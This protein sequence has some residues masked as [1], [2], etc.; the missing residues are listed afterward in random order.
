[1]RRDERP[2][3]LAMLFSRSA[4]C[5]RRLKYS[6]FEY[7]HRNKER[8]LYCTASWPA[9][10]RCSP[11]ML[12]ALET[13]P[14]WRNKFWLRYRRKTTSLLTRKDLICFTIFARTGLFTCVSRTMW[15]SRYYLNLSTASEIL[16]PNLVALQD[17]QR[18]RAFL[19]LNE[20]KRRFQAAYGQGAQTALAYAMNSEFS[21]VLSNEMVNN[22]Y[23]SS[24]RRHLKLETEITKKI[25]FVTNTSWGFLS[26]ISSPRKKKRPR[27]TY[28]WDPFI[29]NL[30]WFKYS[31]EFG[32]KN[33]YFF[34]IPILILIVFEF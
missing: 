13:S 25:T 20:I 27:L 19:Y 8:C 14:K 30:N 16:I 23:Y 18:S 32:Q 33:S 1:M 21:R 2:R 22:D 17:F 34:Q 9:A 24:Y 28:I 10:L 5:L 3:I 15:V 12:R 31:L 7:F 29:G 11:S 4:L 26:L 6:V